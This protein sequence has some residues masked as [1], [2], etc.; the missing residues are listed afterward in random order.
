[1]VHVQEQLN[2][3]DKLCKLTSI[4]LF[5]CLCLVL[6]APFLYGQAFWREEQPRKAYLSKVW[7]YRLSGFS[8]QAYQTAVEGLFADFERRTGKALSPKKRG[9]VGIKVDT[10]AGKGLSTPASLVKALM[11]V[12]R[13]RGFEQEKIF[14]LDAA[15]APLR[16]SGYIPSLGQLR[17]NAELKFQGSPVLILDS[18]RY[19]DPLWHYESPLPIPYWQ[20]LP[21]LSGRLQDPFEQDERKSFL[22]VPLMLE[23][24]F[25]INIPTGMDH[26]ALGLRGA[27][28]NASLWN[29]SN[30]ERFFTSPTNAPVAAAEIA[31]IPELLNHWA[32]TLFP[33]E[34][35][36]FIGGPDFKAKYTHSEPLLWMGVNPAML[37]ALLLKRINQLREASGFRSTIAGALLR[38]AE[39][40]G[41][42]SS[43]IEQVEWL[44][45]EPID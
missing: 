37:D 22:P 27:I 8:E 15:E 29:V 5:T 38:Y 10:Q 20:K 24:D 18:G 30:R 17:Q 33:L 39:N 7:E 35:Y 23:V 4:I 13:K 2:L 43:D 11:N 44:R 28:A 21:S 14:V 40:V 41:L 26:P 45:P 3:L 9:R 32:M 34:A 6:N 25:W 42:G 19:Y 36:Q 12:L 1:M 16:A 31:A